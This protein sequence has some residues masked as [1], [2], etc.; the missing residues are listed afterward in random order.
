MGLWV[1]NND[2]SAYGFIFL[3]INW[4]CI[5]WCDNPGLAAFCRR[6]LLFNHI[7]K[8]GGEEWEQSSISFLPGW[9]WHI[10]MTVYP[11]GA[12]LG[13]Q[14]FASYWFYYFMHFYNFFLFRWDQDQKGWSCLIRHP[15]IMSPCAKSRMSC[16]KCTLTHQTLWNI[17]MC[18]TADVGPMQ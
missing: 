14:N 11:P 9:I 7:L 5:E 8:L 4:F 1:S 18:F 2:N 15:A 10:L 13:A 6:V 12:G 17:F 16:Q 3:W